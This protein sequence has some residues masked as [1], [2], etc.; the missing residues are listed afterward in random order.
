MILLPEGAALEKNGH[1][2]KPRITFRPRFCC[3]RRSEAGATFHRERYSSPPLFSRCIGMWGKGS[4]PLFSFFPPPFSSGALSRSIPNANREI[5]QKKIRATSEDSSG[6]SSSP[7]RPRS[8]KGAAL[9]RAERD[10]LLLYRLSLAA[11][12]TEGGGGGKRSPSGREGGGGGAFPAVAERGRG[13]GGGGW[14]MASSS[15]DPAGLPNQPGAPQQERYAAG[16]GV[17]RVALF[18]SLPGPLRFL[19][20]LSSKRSPVLPSLCPFT[21]LRCKNLPPFRRSLSLPPRFCRCRCYR[22]YSRTRL[23]KKKKRERRRR[24]RRG[25][26]KQPGT[27]THARPAALPQPPSSW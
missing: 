17:A 11:L 14:E 1:L 5:T 4:G 27:Q 8:R 23:G 2:S 10:S 25:G 18:P 21:R 7:R 6:G 16:L 20:R 15:P 13:G 24:R 22:R 12:L 19:P 3:G 26:K 9:R